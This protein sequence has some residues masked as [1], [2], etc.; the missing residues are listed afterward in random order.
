MEKFIG[1]LIMLTISFAISAQELQ[2]VKYGINPVGF[3]S[4]LVTDHSRPSRNANQSG[5]ALQINVWYPAKNQAIAPMNFSRYVY[6]KGSEDSLVKSDQRKTSV[7]QTYLDEL[8]NG[9]ADIRSWR[10]FLD[11]AIPMK[12]K[13]NATFLP[14]DYPVILLIHGAAPDYCFLGEFLAS[15]GM[16]AINVPYKGYLQNKFDVN[17]IGMETEIRD[18][19]YAFDHVVKTFELQPKKLGLVGLSFGG[20]SAVGLA[21]RNKMVK[22]IVSL[23]GGIG[24]SFGPQL[25]ADHPFYHIEK[26]NMPLLHL[27]NPADSGG[28]ID[29]FNESQYTDRWLIPFKHMDHSFFASFGLLDNYINNVI[30]PSKPRAGNNYE[31]ILAF[32]LKFFRELFDNLSNSASITD[33]PEQNPWMAESLESISFRKKE[34]TPISLEDLQNAMNEK[35]I[36]ALRQMHQKHKSITN[37]PITDNSY[38]TLFLNLFNEQDKSGMLAITELYESDFPMSALAKYFRGHAFQ[39]NEK[40]AEAK[41]YFRKCLELISNDVSLSQGEKEAYANRCESLLKG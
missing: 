6:L 25:L 1:A 2:H 15:H 4:M 36:D 13:I 33:L 38:R 18:H 29:W 9:G 41:E 40:S 24:S 11:K 7:I 8:A 3:K 12:A 34:F 14:G 19:E 16:I 17:V 26:V 20:Q 27:Y 35:G 39:V 37:M 31:V 28:N 30:G 21:V 22:G 32:T 5:R 23:D 10:S